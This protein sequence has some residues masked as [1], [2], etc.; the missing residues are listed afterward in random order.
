MRYLLDTHTLTWAVG[1]PSLQSE[2]AVELLSDSKNVLLVSP[3]SVW[4]MSIKH[5]A[6]RWPEVAPFLDD[7]Q[8]DG[9]S[10][11]LGLLELPIHVVHTRLAGQFNLAHKDPFDRL[12]AAQALLEGVGLTSKD[13]AFDLFPITR[14]W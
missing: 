7:R 13:T 2:K 1:D 3:A 5:R 11:H 8:Y 6:G 12:L 9:F 10:Q 14:V 4:E